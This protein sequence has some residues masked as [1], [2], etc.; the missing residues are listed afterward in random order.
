MMQSATGNQE[1]DPDDEAIEQLADLDPIDVLL[2]APAGCGKTEALAHRAA[3]LIRNGHVRPEQ[4]ILAV[5]FSNKARDNLRARLRKMLPAHEMAKVN[6]SNLHGVAA[7]IVLAHGQ[8]VGLETAGLVL[9]TRRAHRRRQSLAGIVWQNRDQVEVILRT[10]KGGQFDDD[11]VRQ[12]IEDSGN[13]VAL[14]YQLALENEEGLD[15]DDL[16]RH[17]DRILAI[18][19]VAHGYQLHVAAVLVDEVQDLSL[20]QLRI[21]QQ[22][23]T[24]RITYA[25]DYGQGIYSFAGADPDGVFASIA[26]RN[27]RVFQLTRSFRS[28]PAVLQ[29]VN[30]LAAISGTTTLRCADPDRWGPDATSS[31]HAFASVDDEAIAVLAHVQPLLAP[32]ASVGII[33]RNGNRLNAIRTRAASVGQQFTDWSASLHHV[34]TV[35]Q[36][37]EHVTA[38]IRASSDNQEALAALRQMCLESCREDDVD[39]RDEIEEACAEL[40]QL[41]ESGLA[42]DEAVARC[43]PDEP[44]DAPVRPGLHL[45]N[46]HLGKGQEFDHVVILGLEEGIVPDFR[47]VSP[48]AVA[49]ELRTLTVMVSRAR[50]SLYLTTSATV[51]TTNGWENP[52]QPSR[53]WPILT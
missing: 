13:E 8:R 43:R 51:P 20:Q 14:R 44:G 35:R 21:V 16:L 41:T 46:A 23:G 48:S 10:A 1:K 38:A 53:W 5:S 17:A 45:L 19:E 39:T 3:R 50:T 28:S 37:R 32:D 11:H 7:R 49:E 52:R 2:T 25:G 47:A 40:A 24:D 22:V 27:P 15:F 31:G 34:D 26:S 30:A 33:A 9:P 42:L 36:L 29:A 12:K 6:V 4:K 18:K